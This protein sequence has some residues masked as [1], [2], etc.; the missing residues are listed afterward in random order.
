[1]TPGF[2]WHPQARQWSA[3]DHLEFLLITAA[4][5]IVAYFLKYAPAPNLAPA[6]RRLAQ[7]HDATFVVELTRG[8]LHTGTLA[9]FDAPRRNPRGSPC[10]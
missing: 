5:F 3:K 8:F 4:T 9:P 6:A 7:A 1:M 2:P 10:W